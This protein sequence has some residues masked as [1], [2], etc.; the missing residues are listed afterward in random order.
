MAAMFT[1]AHLSDV[2]LPPLPRA[3]PGALMS[4][5]ILGYLNWH[6]KRKTIHRREAL[7]TLIDDLKARAP[8]HIAVT[9][10][11]AN[12]SLPAEFS[13][14]KDWLEA[15]GPGEDIT[16]VPGN[17]DA[18]VD[19]PWEESIGLWQ[20]NMAGDAKAVVRHAKNQ[21][22]FPFVRMR[23]PC[24]LTGLSTA[25][26][27]PPFMATGSLDEAQLEALPKILKAAREKGLFRIILIHHPPL[28]ALASRHKCLVNADGLASIIQSEGAELVLYGHNHLQA[29]DYLPGPD[30]QIPLVG[31]PSASAGRT[32][33]KP[34]ARY[35]LFE[36]SGKPGQWICEMTGRGLNRPGG[37]IETVEKVL[38]FQG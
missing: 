7:A 36:I 29:L 2:H 11:L 33:H 18:Y 25:V 35:N 9:G 12:I 20:A 4:K 3:T 23:G 19:L 26:S 5:R 10:D 13:I 16:V 38:L 28:D 37:R 34:L 17:H 21:Q 14:A 8:D 31:V 6:R 32:G 27:T 24:A 15:L 1:L 22:G 30:S